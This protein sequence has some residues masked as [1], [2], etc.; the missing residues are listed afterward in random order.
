MKSGTQWQLGSPW[1]LPA[2]AV[3]MSSGQAGSIPAPQL[4]SC[5]GEQTR[6]N[7]GPHSLHPHPPCPDPPG[8]PDPDPPGCPDPD[9]LGPPGPPEPD[10]DPL[11]PPGC[12]DPLG[13]PE[14]VPLGPA[15]VTLSIEHKPLIR[16]LPFLHWTVKE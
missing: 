8:C 10:P 6:V 12:P 15:V 3:I 9:P 14:V 2:A 4:P 11:G 1:E 16:H 13:P 5:S 7:P